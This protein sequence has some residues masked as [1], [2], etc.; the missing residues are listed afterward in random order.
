MSWSEGWILQSVWIEFLVH[1]ETQVGS[2]DEKY[3]GIGLEETYIN[4]T[5]EIKV[6]SSFEY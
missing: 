4:K 2:I 3:S 6:S 1:E 5:I